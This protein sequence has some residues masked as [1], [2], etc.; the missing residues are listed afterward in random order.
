M[1]VVCEELR[2]VPRGE[3]LSLNG[4][5]LTKLMDLVSAARLFMMVHTLGWL[6]PSNLVDSYGGESI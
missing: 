5:K 1:Q 6:K 2:R 4:R 3:S